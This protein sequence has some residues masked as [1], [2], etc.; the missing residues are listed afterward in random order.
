MARFFMRRRGRQRSTVEAPLEFPDNSASGYEPF[1]DASAT[2]LFDGPGGT[3]DEIQSRIILLE[4]RVAQLE[5]QRHSA[6]PPIITPETAPTSVAET[7]S[8]DLESDE[9]STDEIYARLLLKYLK[10]PNPSSAFGSLEL[11]TIIGELRDGSIAWW[12]EAHGYAG[13]SSPQVFDGLK[14]ERGAVVRARVV[15]HLWGCFVTVVV[16]EISRPPSTLQDI[17][18]SDNV[19][20][21]IRSSWQSDLEPGD[22]V[23]ARVP[24]DGFLPIDRKGRIA[25]NRPAV[26]IRWQ[27][28]YALVRA[29]YDADGYVAANDIGEELE[30]TNCLNKKSVVRN[31]EY[32]LSPSNFLHHIGQV[33]PNDAQRLNLPVRT[34][35]LTRIHQQKKTQHRVSDERTHTPPTG[36]ERDSTSTDLRLALRSVRDSVGRMNRLASPEEVLAAL[37]V[38][39]VSNETANSALRTSGIKYAFLGDV[40]REA[41]E[42]CGVQYQ[43]GS[44]SSMLDQ[45][46]DVWNANNQT[47]LGKRLDGDNLPVLVVVDDT[48]SST[49]AAAPDAEIGESHEG[50]GLDLPEDY[51][52]PDVIIYD[53]FS[54]AIITGEVRL[55]LATE[56]QR[57]RAGSTAPAYLIGSDEHAAWRGFQEAARHRGWSIRTASERADQ[58]ATAES[59]ARSHGAQVVTI[60]S[61]HADMV[62]ALENL[63]PIVNVVSSVS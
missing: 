28:D 63:G 54:G 18:T 10:T 2:S 45:H 34:T 31:A 8:P 29:I 37:I 48:V 62:A 13:A 50:L 26:F 11:I 57:L 16:P 36:I 21:S 42:V 23:L 44:L 17:L 1:G 43:R 22:I 41:C 4:D 27:H 24:Y 33:G 15:S 46:L 5:S 55:D 59:I 19:P 39:I 32:D 9:S 20:E 51:V 14:F 3:R 60:V 6:P 56:L 35:T 30:D 53:Q 12:C 61:A 40:L 49:G 25:K 47:R 38:Q 7:Y 52:V 58:V